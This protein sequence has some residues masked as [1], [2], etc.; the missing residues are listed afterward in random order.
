MVSHMYTS[1]HVQYNVQTCKKQ[2][3]SLKSGWQL[4]LSW[5]QIGRELTGTGW[6]EREHTGTGCTLVRADLLADKHAHVRTTEEEVCPVWC[7]ERG[8]LAQSRLIT[9]SGNKS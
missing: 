4:Q 9:V 1:T 3:A 8:L 7:V 2:A 6:T 5:G